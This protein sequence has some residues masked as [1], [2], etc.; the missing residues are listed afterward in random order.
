M[1]H[2]LHKKYEPGSHLVS[3]PGAFLCH[4]SIRSI[5]PTCSVSYQT[6]SWDGKASKLLETGDAFLLEHNERHGRDKAGLLHS[7]QWSLGGWWHCRPCS[8]VYQYHLASNLGCMCSFFVPY[9]SVCLLALIFMH[10]SGRTIWMVLV[11][12]GWVFSSCWSAMSC[13]REPWQS[14]CCYQN[15]CRP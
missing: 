11:K 10:R 12:T 8:L 3:C 4:C 13:R 15:L 7:V 6:E 5:D 1:W 14:K 2:V 9:N